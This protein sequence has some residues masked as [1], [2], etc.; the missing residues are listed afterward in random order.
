MKNLQL[1]F[2]V[3]IKVRTL[4]IILCQHVIE[5]CYCGCRLDK[6]EIFNAMH[7]IWYLYLWL[8]NRHSS[9]VDNLLYHQHGVILSL[10]D[11]V[12]LSRSPF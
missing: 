11:K 2:T 10:S 3:K 4:K 6:G 12:K 8:H 7:K 5:G 9:E 1:S